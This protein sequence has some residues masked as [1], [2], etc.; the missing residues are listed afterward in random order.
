[1]IIIIIIE[2]NKGKMIAS[3]VCCDYSVAFG[4]AS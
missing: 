2:K 4:Y 1:M 3:V